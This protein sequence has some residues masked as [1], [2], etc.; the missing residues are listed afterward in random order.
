VYAETQRQQDYD[1]DIYTDYILVNESSKNIQGRSLSLSYPKKIT[2]SYRYPVR[3]NDSE[4]KTVELRFAVPPL[5]SD[6]PNQDILNINYFPDTMD[7]EIDEWGQTVA[8]YEKTL[9]PGEETSAGY[10][11]EAIVYDVTHH[12]DPEQVQGEIPLEILDAY[13]ADVETMYAI[14][15]PIIQDAVAVAVG[16]ET[17]LYQKAKLLHDYVLENVD[18]ELDYVWDPAPI[19]LSNGS[20]SCSEFVFLYI[21]LCRAAGIPARYVSATVFGNSSGPIETL[22]HFDDMYHRWAEVYLP[23]YGWVPVDV[24]WD[25]STSSD[26]YFGTTPNWLVASSISGGPS[27]LL[28]WSHHGFGVWDGDIEVL[29]VGAEWTDWEAATPREI[30]EHAA[31]I[32]ERSQTGDS[33]VDQLIALSAAD[34]RASLDDQY[35]LDDAHLNPNS[36]RAVF[37]MTSWSIWRLSMITQL[38]GVSFETVLEELIAADELLVE[39]TADEAEELSAACESYIWAAAQMLDWAYDSLY[40][41]KAHHD[42]SR[43]LFS[44][45]YYMDAWTLAQEASEWAAAACSDWLHP[46][47]ECTLDDD[48]D[49]GVSCNG[50]E[51][52]VEGFC[53]AGGPGC[54]VG[55]TCEFNDGCLSGFCA[56]GVCE[57]PESGDCTEAVA[58][59][60]GAYGDETTVPTDGCV[61]VRDQY[62]YWWGTRTMLFQT[63]TPGDYPVPFTWSSACTGS[64]GAGI[65]TSDWDNQWLTLTDPDC[66][67]LID[68][69]GSGAGTVRLRYYGG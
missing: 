53:K 16:D 1:L 49:D 26:M 21:A 62:P 27:S 35:W 23:G 34:I 54:E 63:T 50:E 59:D 48:C 42:E 24:T 44:I 8:I 31:A 11:V 9:E 30:K 22:P 57:I 18:Y 56:N 51:T 14:Y 58:V 13:T 69:Q 15:D 36:G 5:S 37:Y 67:T 40:E 28:D 4:P 19:I 12:I 61:M 45:W 20:G 33:E 3:N 17:N 66:A 52:C 10:E 39:T 64:R 32:L 60:L 29:D 7:F 65:F 25:D 41:A 68:L 38:Y 2:Y 47:D 46:G 43:Y 6:L 55:E